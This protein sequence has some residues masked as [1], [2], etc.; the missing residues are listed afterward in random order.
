MGPMLET[1]CNKFASAHLRRGGLVF[2]V[3][4][5]IYLFIYL[6]IFI[7]ICTCARFIVSF[8]IMFHPIKDDGNTGKEQVCYPRYNELSRKVG[9]RNREKKERP[10]PRIYRVYEIESATS[11]LFPGSY[12]NP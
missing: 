3:P 8:G 11:L 7:L 4:S 2:K 10:P 1:Y 12:F 5:D 9:Y 6:F